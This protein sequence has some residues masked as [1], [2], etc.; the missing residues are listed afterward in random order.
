[1]KKS[2]SIIEI[3]VVIL[4]LTIISSV[5]LN[6]YFTTLEKSN[7]LKIKSEV[8]MI[9]NALSS[10]YS[11]QVLSNNSIFILEQLDDAM[12]E[13]EDETLFNG[14]NEYVLL[15][16]VILSTTSEKMKLG[17][18]IKLSQTKYKA[19]LSKTKSV[20][21]NFDMENGTFFCDESDDVCKELSL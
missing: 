15:D 8:A 14:H 16:Y 11:N 7:Y 12:I 21:F 6:K 13:T 1:M 18:W 9:N 3:I 5:A 2:F 4:I 20:T 10:L 19:Y 17:F